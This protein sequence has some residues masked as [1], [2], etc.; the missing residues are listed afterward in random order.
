MRE[1]VGIGQRRDGLADAMAKQA[2]ADES[3]HNPALPGAEAVRR[4]RAVDQFY[5]IANQQARQAEL[6]RQGGINLL[7][8][9]AQSMLD[10]EE[11]VEQSR[12]S[13]EA[14]D[15]LAMMAHQQDGLAAAL[16]R[17]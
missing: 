7:R 10:A 16:G 4:S 5:E 3:P 2:T 17:E 15:T 1:Y 11:L 12:V 9:G 6:I 13:R 8:Q 14:A